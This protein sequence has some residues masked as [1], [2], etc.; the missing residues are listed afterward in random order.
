[1]NKNELEEGKASLKRTFLY[2][3]RIVQE[4]MDY[5]VIQINVV[6]DWY[7]GLTKNKEE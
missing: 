3:S 1:M 2:Y 7:I 6:L 4:E 5:L